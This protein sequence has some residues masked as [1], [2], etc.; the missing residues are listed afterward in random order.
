MSLSWSVFWDRASYKNHRWVVNAESY[1]LFSP[2]DVLRVAGSTAQ[3]NQRSSER[4]LPLHYEIHEYTKIPPNPS[5]NN[6]PDRSPRHVQQ[7]TTWRSSRR[8]ATASIIYHWWIRPCWWD[9][10][11]RPTPVENWD[12]GEAISILSRLCMIR[13]AILTMNLFLCAH[14]LK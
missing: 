9:I 4:I 13:A 8:K 2:L 1:W 10:P 5:S 14:L 7:S 6:T 12:S 3:R 11:L